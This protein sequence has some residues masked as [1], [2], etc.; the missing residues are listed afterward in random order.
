MHV[1]AT[2]ADTEPRLLDRLREKCPY[3]EPKSSLRAALR[4][5]EAVPAGH[6]VLLIL[7]QFEQWLHANQGDSQEALAEALRH[8]DGRH[9]QCLLL[10]REEY[11]TAVTRFVNQR[12]ETRLSQER[13]YALVDLFDKRHARRVLGLFGRAYG[14]LPASGGLTDEQERFLE[15]AAAQLAQGDFVICVRLA[16]LA[17]MLRAKEWNCGTLAQWAAQGVGEKFLLEN[18]DPRTAPPEHRPHH[19]AAQAVLQELLGEGADIRGA[20]CPRGRLLEVSGYAHRPE[21]FEELLEILNHRLRLIT[22]VEA[23]ADTGDSYYVL[24][25]DYLVPS[26]RNG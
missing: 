9:L 13:N 6:K 18:F 22:P 8:C 23:P 1:E 2:A 12:L 15:E 20:A 7:D 24:T 19:R 25:H 16:L 11:A 17:D 26:V 5:K 10:V 14:A 4:R 3:L 21:A